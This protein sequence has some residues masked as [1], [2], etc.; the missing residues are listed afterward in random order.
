MRQNNTL[1]LDRALATASRRSTNWREMPT[2]FALALAVTTWGGLLAAIALGLGAGD[3]NAAGLIVVV[4]A[5]VAVLVL[6]GSLGSILGVV[7]SVG[8]DR[9][10][11][12]LP[13][14]VGYYLLL[15]SLAGSAVL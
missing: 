8:N 13:V 12:L 1:K 7:L 2:R 11:P 5:A 15:W 6:L 4:F 14:S 9:F 10:D 3:P